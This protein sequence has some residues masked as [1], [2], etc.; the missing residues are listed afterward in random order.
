[1]SMIN[2]AIFKTRR[3]EKDAWKSKTCV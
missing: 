3:I 1:V 2:Q